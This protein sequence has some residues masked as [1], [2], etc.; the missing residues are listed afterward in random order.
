[1]IANFSSTP[2]Y[3]RAKLAN[4]L[5]TRELA[6]RLAGDGIVVHAMHP[7]LV[8]SNFANHGDDAM[9]SY[10]QANSDTSISPR[11][12]ADTLIWLA[13]AEQPGLTTGQYF[14]ERTSIATSPA[15][16][17]AA[18]AKRLWLESEKLVG[19]SLAQYT[20]T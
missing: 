18:A 4:I 11:D 3:C 15:A 5:F 19:H 7:G 17:D 8:S 10:L 14:H 6:R 16:K 20:A 12:A 9:Q 2:A 13:S 1:M